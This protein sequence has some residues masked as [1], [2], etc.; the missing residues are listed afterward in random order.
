MTD[1]T[2]IMCRRTA[3]QMLAERVGF[4]LLWRRRPTHD[5]EYQICLECAVR[6]K[7]EQD[8]R[9]QEAVRQAERS[10]V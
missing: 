3:G 4:Q 2:C 5:S 6:V 1:D 8:Q 10:G 9:A 7:G